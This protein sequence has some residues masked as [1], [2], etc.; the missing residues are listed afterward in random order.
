MAD[1]L[2]GGWMPRQPSAKLDT[3]ICDKEHAIAVP[4]EVL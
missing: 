2:K 4:L 3:S 1:Q